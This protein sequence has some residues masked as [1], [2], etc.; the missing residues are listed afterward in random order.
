MLS[1]TD[2]SKHYKVIVTSNTC[3]QKPVCIPQC[4]SLRCQYLCQ[5]M[6]SCSCWDYTVGHLCKHCHKV[7]GI[8]CETIDTSQELPQDLVV[9]GYGCNP[10]AKKE[11]EA[12]AN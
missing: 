1:C 8:V 4:N 12:G 6:I 9:D 11:S 5:H 2:A 3:E 10:E 7:W